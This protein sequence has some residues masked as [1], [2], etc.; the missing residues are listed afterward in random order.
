MAASKQ[1]VEELARH[2]QL[3]WSPQ[4]KRFLGFHRGIIFD[5]RLVEGD[6]YIL[7]VS[8]TVQLEEQVVEGF[9]DFTNTEATGVPLGCLSYVQYIDQ[10]NSI[11]PHACVVRLLSMH[12]EKLGYDRFQQ[13]P[14]AIAKDFHHHGAEESLVCQ[15]CQDQPAEQVL[16]AGDR[17]VPICASCEHAVQQQ[18]VA[19]KL[20]LQQEVN[21]KLTLPLIVILT[22]AGAYLWGTLRQPAVVKILRYATL[23]IPIVWGGLFCL[24]V[25]MVSGGTNRI[26][27]ILLYLAVALSLF[28]GNIW[29]F[30]SM[31]E[32]AA[33]ERAGDLL[34]PPDMLENALYYLKTLPQSWEYDAML[35]VLGL[36]GAW[37]V[38]QPASLSQRVRVG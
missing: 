26:L 20:H 12:Q 24:L 25:H 22:L 27:R 14:D 23:L 1:W 31:M 18:V 13:L 9:K 29:C 7:C 28:L 2:Y 30:C 34:Q 11:S 33:I 36:V 8:P 16:M 37:F 6:I 17:H 32:K 10:K 15:E 35:I 5:I 4:R 3:R 19:G 21:W 38:L